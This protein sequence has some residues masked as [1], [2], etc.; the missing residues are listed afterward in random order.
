MQSRKLRKF[1]LNFRRE[2]RLFVHFSSLAISMV[3][4]IKMKIW[5]TRRFTEARIQWNV[6]L[7]MNENKILKIH[8]SLQAIWVCIFGSWLTTHYSLLFHKQI[9]KWMRWICRLDQFPI[10]S[11]VLVCT[12]PNR[13]FGDWRKEERDWERKCVYWLLIHTQNTHSP[14]Q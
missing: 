12:L 10:Y 2:N 14:T 6:R 13:K 11:L 9:R 4:K 1:R 8:F 7:R 5:K 3:D